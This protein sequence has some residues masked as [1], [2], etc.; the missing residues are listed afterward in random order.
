MQALLK[1]I[2][3]E[4]GDDGRILLRK[5]GTEPVVRVMVE[6]QSDE[7]CRKYVDLMVQKMSEEKLIVEVKNNAGVI[8]LRN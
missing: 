3:D 1:Q 8:I 4:L 2:V 5:S 7:I 6:A